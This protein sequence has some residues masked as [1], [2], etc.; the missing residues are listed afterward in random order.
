MVVT[1]GIEHAC[2]IA[3]DGHVEC[4]GAGSKPPND[5]KDNFGQ[6]MPPSGSFK[7]LSAGYYHTCG[8]ASDDTV[9]CWGAGTT[10]S[11]CAGLTECGQA[12]PPSGKF[13]E[14]AGNYTNSCGIRA[15]GTLTCWGSN[16]GNRST[17]PSDFQ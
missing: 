13:Q 1:C 3:T 2:A 16:T 4:W 12:M 11:D 7:S 8:I 6:A 10:S 9:K 15:D 5:A 17:P 14:I